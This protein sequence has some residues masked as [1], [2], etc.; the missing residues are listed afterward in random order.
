MALRDGT[1]KGSARLPGTDWRRLKERV[2]GMLAIASINKE[3]LDQR[4]GDMQGLPKFQERA[5]PRAIYALL[6]FSRHFRCGRI[7]QEWKGEVLSRHKSDISAASVAKCGFGRF[8]VLNGADTAFTWITVL[9]RSPDNQ[10]R[11]GP[12][13]SESLLL[14]QHAC[15]RW[16]CC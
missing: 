1:G 6:H 15:I 11:M 16:S 4:S 3:G 14:Q 10:P 12:M 2:I 9:G 8:F 5:L 7:A 13:M